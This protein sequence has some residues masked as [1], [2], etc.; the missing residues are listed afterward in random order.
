MKKGIS[1]QRK[2]GVPD[3]FGLHKIRV[4][5]RKETDNRYE[6]YLLRSSDVDDGRRIE[7]FYRDGVDML[8][9]G[10]IRASIENWR[11][12]LLPLLGLVQSSGGTVLRKGDFVYGN[13]SEGGTCQGVFLKDNGDGALELSGPS[14]KFQCLAGGVEFV[15]DQDIEEILRKKVVKIRKDNGIRR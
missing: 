4:T 2:A 11:E 1:I 5:Y 3:G 8:E 10:G 7:I 12:I 13:K 9:V 15:P 14:L 6:G